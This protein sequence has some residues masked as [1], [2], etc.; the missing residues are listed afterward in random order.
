MSDEEDVPTYRV[1]VIIS[2]L[3]NE[4]RTVELGECTKEKIE[5]IVLNAQRSFDTVRASQVLMLTGTDGAF[6]M[7][8]L[9]NIVFVEVHV[10]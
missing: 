1:R 8:N 6:V 9:D 2:S 10:G 5:E 7:A 3:G 4:R